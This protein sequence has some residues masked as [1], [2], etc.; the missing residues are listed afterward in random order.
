MPPY[1]QTHLRRTGYL[2]LLLAL[3][4]P[5]CQAPRTA[6]S[7]RAFLEETAGPLTGDLA[8]RIAARDKPHVILISLDTLRA[9][10]LGSYGYGRETSPFL[11]ELAS[12][13]VR[14]EEVISQS[15]KTAPS[16]MSLFTGVYPYAHGT[17]FIYEE[18]QEQGVVPLSQELE[19]LPTWFREMGYRTA[20]WAG[21]GQMGAEAGFGRGFDEFHEN[22]GD[23]NREK[24]LAIL[25]WFRERSDRPCFLFLH[26]YQIHDPYM[27][28][29]PYN[30]MYY[31]DYQ[32]WVV[33]DRE[34]LRAMAG[35]EDFFSVQQAFWRMD[36]KDEESLDA[37]QFSPDDLRKL[38]ALYDGGIR[39]TDD[40]LRRF[41]DGLAREGLLDNTLIAITSDHGEEFLEHGGLLHRVLYRETLRVPMI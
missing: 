29:A 31:P 19:V 25:D 33:G 26:T 24:M 3:A 22:L 34:K 5:A 13:G 27:P 23:I 6:E 16:H 8:A 32:G 38:I 40:L 36:S 18:R 1:R 35:A 2:V 41:F 9:D 12:F 30:T 4:L 7:A 21:G 11:D 37:T 28:P 15:P 10:H 20:A 17:H 39:Y 14:F